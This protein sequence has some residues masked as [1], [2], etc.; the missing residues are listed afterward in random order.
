M[1]DYAV[2]NKSTLVGAD[3]LCAKI[4]EAERK[5]SPTFCGAWNLAPC[6][7]EI[8]A[9]ESQAK[10]C[11]MLFVLQDD[12]PNVP[13]AFGYHDEQNGVPYSR[14]LTATVLAAGG[15]QLDGG[16]IGVSILG[17]ALHELWEAIVDKFVD[18]L[19]LMPSGIFVFKEAADPVQAN[20]IAVT[21]DDGSVG[22]ASDGVLPRYF[23]A[24]APTDGSEPLSLSA[25][26]GGPGPGAPFGIM[27]GGY[28]SQFDP[29]K[30]ADPNGPIV[31]VWGAQVPAAVKAAKIAGGRLKDL[32]ERHMKHVG[33][34]VGRDYV[35]QHRNVA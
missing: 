8:V 21:F 27:P 25:L 15:G 24:Q 4:V 19:V 28:Q 16:S 3:A 30:I 17:V 2:L 6:S 18:D 5:L 9:D 20:S 22:L 1:F 35:W 29:S 13:N 11:D 7:G 31:T 14:V 10:S 23:D 12:D 32:V 33:A 26:L 34:A